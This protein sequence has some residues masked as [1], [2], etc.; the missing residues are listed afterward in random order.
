M[1]IAFSRECF[2]TA[3][4]QDGALAHQTCIVFDEAFLYWRSSPNWSS[5]LPP[6]FQE[7]TVR[8][9]HLNALAPLGADALPRIEELRRLAF[10]TLLQDVNGSAEGVHQQD[11]NPAER[12]LNS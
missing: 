9:R 4:G 3:L 2:E 11:A 6:Y 8:R 12:A 5:V 1:A 7:D 10:A